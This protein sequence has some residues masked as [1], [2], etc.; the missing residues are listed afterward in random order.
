MEVVWV[1]VIASLGSV[2]A[3]S[4]FW[5]YIQRKDNTK[6][7][8]YRLLRSLA[9]TELMR[10]GLI[11]IERGWISRD[12]LEEYEEGLYGPYKAFGG[13]GVAERIR[14]DVVRLPIQSYKRY[15]EKA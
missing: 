9:Y 5:A 11:Y 10:Q 4:G 2:I 6:N 8:M 14:G 7:A 3:S 13:N 15:S 1:A 12:E